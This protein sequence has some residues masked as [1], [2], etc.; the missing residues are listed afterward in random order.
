VSYLLSLAEIRQLARIS[1]D[2]TNLAPF[3]ALR[4][5]IS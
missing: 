4:A 5:H 1:G 3:R 2:R